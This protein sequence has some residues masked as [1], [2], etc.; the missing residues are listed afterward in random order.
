[1]SRASTA[2]ISALVP[3]EQERL[4]AIKPKGPND[5][6]SSVSNFGAGGLLA[7]TYLRNK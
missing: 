6:T 4:H 3:F 5:I 1:M 7:P 2:D